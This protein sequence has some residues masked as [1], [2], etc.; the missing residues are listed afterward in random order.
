MTHFRNWNERLTAANGVLPAELFYSRKSTTGED[1]QVASHEQQKE[2]ITEKFGVF[3]EIWWFADSCTGTTFDRPQFTQLQEFCRKNRR[4]QSD[5]GE[6]Y[7]YDP[8]RFG[9]VLDEEGKPDIL[10]FLGMSGD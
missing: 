6:I 2:S 7:I 5:P 4:S 9:R 10:A 1:R 8:S 3:D